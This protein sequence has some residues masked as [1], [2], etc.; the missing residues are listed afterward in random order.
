VVVSISG[1]W[2]C[3][4]GLM[5]KRAG[6]SETSVPLHGNYMASHPRRR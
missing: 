1:M 2:C 6:C 5:M 4:V 3:V